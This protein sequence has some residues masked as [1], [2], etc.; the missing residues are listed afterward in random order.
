MAQPPQTYELTTFST[1]VL[2]C[3]AAVFI[4]LFIKT[5]L[6]CIEWI[7]N[8]RSSNEGPG[9]VQKKSETAE[10]SENDADDGNISSEL[11]DLETKKVN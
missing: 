3:V 8:L 9:E 6:N 2:L 11:P 5:L 7:I 1:L 10:V 4:W